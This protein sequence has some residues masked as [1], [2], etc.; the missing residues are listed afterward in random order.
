MF[1]PMNHAH[2][3]TAEPLTAV[4]IDGLLGELGYLETL[5]AV[6]HVEVAADGGLTVWLDPTAGE[7]PWLDAPRP[8]RSPDVELHGQG[9]PCRALVDHPRAEHVE[10]FFD[11]LGDPMSAPRGWWHAR[12][13]LR[14]A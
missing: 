4:E 1:V 10:M 8:E 11:G 5:P 2:P 7:A 3:V 14:A 12:V 9:A 6:G 13:W